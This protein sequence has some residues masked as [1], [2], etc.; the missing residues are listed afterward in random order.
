MS[1]V[2]VNEGA[3]HIATACADIPTTINQLLGLAGV[4]TL[5]GATLVVPLDGRH[6]LAHMALD[7]SNRRGWTF[8]RHV[9]PGMEVHLLD[10]DGPDANPSDVAS[11]VAALQQEAREALGDSELGEG[12]AVLRRALA[13][14]W[15]N[16]GPWHPDTLWAASNLLHVAAATG[17][18]ENLAQAVAL[19][20][21]LM[22]EPLPQQAENPTGILRKLGEVAERC[23][24]NGRHDVA[25]R[26]LAAAVEAARTLL[27]DGH[28]NHLATLNSYGLFLSAQGDPEAATV[29]GTLLDRARALFG[30]DHPNVGVVERNLAEFVRGRG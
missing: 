9:P 13:V 2:L 5:P 28:P 8:S 21:L 3:T 27:G 12:L 23:A 15:R 25:R 1:G 16:L 18:A 7:E 29:L 6:G 22:N 20:D 24:K 4:E 14:G 10:L 30:P 17:A 11:T 26:A 19:T